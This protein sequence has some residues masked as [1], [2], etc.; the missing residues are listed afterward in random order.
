MLNDSCFSHFLTL[1]FVLTDE[2]LDEDVLVANTPTLVDDDDHKCQ[3]HHDDGGGEGY[4]EDDVCFHTLCDF[5]FT[6]Q[7]YY[8]TGK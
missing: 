2:T 4:G 8:K 6:L 3:H 5:E 7:K 1:L